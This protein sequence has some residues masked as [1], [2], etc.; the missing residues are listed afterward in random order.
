MDLIRCEIRVGVVM[1]YIQSG[2]VALLFDQRVVKA[3]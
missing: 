2:D 3:W 1:L